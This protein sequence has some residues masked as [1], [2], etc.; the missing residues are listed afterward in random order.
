MSRPDGVVR[1]GAHPDQRVELRDP[2]PGASP[3]GVALLVH[4]GYWRER[5]TAS[6]MGAL[7]ADLAARGWAVANVEY[8]RGPGTWPAADDDVRAAAAAV[9]AS[10]WRWSWGGPFVGVGHSVGG[11]LV[12]LASEEFDSV[13]ALAPVTDVARVWAEGLGEGAAAEYFGAGPDEL[14]GA[15][16]DAS[17]LRQVPPACPVLV[18]HGD[19]DGRVPLA[20]SLAYARAAGGRDGGRVGLLEVPGM[21]HLEAIDPAGPQWEATVGWMAGAAVVR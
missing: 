16:A 6:L 2:A 13:V 5:F 10:E 4:G 12:L 18:V 19:A 8:R 11:Q 17:P 9:A 3:R 7:A 14:P 20:H 1:Y 15:Y 21:G